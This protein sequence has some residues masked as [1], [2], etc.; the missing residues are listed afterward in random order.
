MFSGEPVS[1]VSPSAIRRVA[2]CQ[3]RTDWPSAQNQLTY[4]LL[5]DIHIPLP[6]FRHPLGI[7]RLCGPR[8][9][10]TV[11]ILPRSPS[12]LFFSFSRS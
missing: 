9:L 7:W 12:L 3:T 2:L 1:L 10:A 4:D 11:P 8:E 5:A 6:L